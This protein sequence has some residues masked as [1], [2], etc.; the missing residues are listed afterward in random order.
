MPVME[1]AAQR[2]GSAGKQ[3]SFEKI[4][5]VVS[6]LQRQINVNLQKNA[7]SLEIRVRDKA[8][9]QAVQAVN[10]VCEAFE[11]AGRE[12]GA[13]ARVKYLERNLPALE[14]QI[15]ELEVK[16][17][18]LRELG[19]RA[20]ERGRLESRQ[21]VLRSERQQLLETYTLQHPEV[22]K[23][24]DE[25]KRLD[26]EL[27]SLVP[28]ADESLLAGLQQELTDAQSRSQSMANELQEARLAAAGEAEPARI[29]RK[30][31]RPLPIRAGFTFL[32]VI[33]SLLIAAVLALLPCLRLFKQP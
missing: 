3:D 9:D 16:I 22:V 6:N 28:S 8:G 32:S 30:A 11:E 18:P 2:L 15:R 26:Q 4:Q 5:G 1:N 33:S 17:Q 19:S 29:L 13:L 20:Q 31:V 14:D 23:R 12:S 27:A 25:I 21:N 10:A 24:E 7:G